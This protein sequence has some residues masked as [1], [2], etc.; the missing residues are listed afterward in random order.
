MFVEVSVAAADQNALRADL[1]ALAPEDW[2]E[3]SVIPDALSA[4]ERSVADLGRAAA[5][6]VFLPIVR[7]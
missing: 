3:L 6:T 1:L 5:P 4:Y 7:R 2:P